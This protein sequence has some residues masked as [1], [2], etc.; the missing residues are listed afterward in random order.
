MLGGIIKV[1]VLAMQYPSLHRDRAHPYPAVIQP[2]WLESSD[3][4]STDHFNRELLRA[5]V[6]RLVNLFPEELVIQEKTISLIHRD[7]MLWYVETIPV[8]D[9]LQVNRVGSWVFSGL[10]IL[11]H[12]P[13][14]DIRVWGLRMQAAEQALN[15][16]K[17]LLLE[18]IGA[19]DIPLHYVAGVRAYRLELAGKEIKE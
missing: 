12:D 2:G 1:E 5:R 6:S 19:V 16:I 7:T 8:K 11:G 3:L 13:D 17:G 18:E 14:H 4:P 9:I 15:M 10:D